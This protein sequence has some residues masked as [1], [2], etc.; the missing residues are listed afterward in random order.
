MIDYKTLIIQFQFLIRK[1]FK[2]NI[3]IGK[4]HEGGTNYLYKILY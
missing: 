3:Y 2:K 1:L 4:E